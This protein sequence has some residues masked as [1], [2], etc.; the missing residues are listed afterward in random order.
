MCNLWNI[1][2]DIIVYIHT[3]THK[4]KN[5]NKKRGL[6]SAQVLGWHD[7][8]PLYTYK[9]NYYASQDNIEKFFNPSER[10]IRQIRFKITMLL[11]QNKLNWQT[12][13]LQT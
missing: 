2:I 3:Y 1:Y 8:P 5:V 12:F 4:N 10:Y 7:I 6:I 13:S 9:K 11:C